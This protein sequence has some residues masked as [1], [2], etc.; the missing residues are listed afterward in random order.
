LVSNCTALLFI[1][2]NFHSSEKSN[3]NDT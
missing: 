2:H 3:S 1:Y